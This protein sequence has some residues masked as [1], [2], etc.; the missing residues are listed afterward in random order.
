MSTDPAGG[1]VG[2]KPDDT[3]TLEE[4][5]EELR[6]RGYL[7]SPLD[8]FLL[9][10]RLRRRLT[11]AGAAATVAARAG[12]L[13]GPLVGIPVAVTASTLASGHG[14]AGALLRLALVLSVA[15]GLLLAL[16]EGAAA[17][18]LRR[19]GGGRAARLAARAG[20]VVAGLGTVYLA[21]WWRARRGNL[22]GIGWLD[23]LS[24][25]LIA[26]LA[27]GLARLTGAAGSALVAAEAAARKQPAPQRPRRRRAAVGVVLAAGLAALLLFA[28]RRAEPA[29]PPTGVARSDPGGRLLVLG[30]DGVGRAELED[31]RRAGLVPSL[32][33]LLAQA[34][35]RPLR[36]PPGLDPPAVWTTYATG[37]W[38][39]GHGVDGVEWQ[40]LAGVP[41]PAGAGPL[42]SA[43][44]EAA[45][46]VLPAPGRV[47]RSRP[48]SSQVRRAPAVWEILGGQGLPVAVAHWWATSPVSRLPGCVIGERAYAR[49]ERGTV[50]V[51]DIHPAARAVAAGR[52]HARWLEAAASRL[53][54]G[55]LDDA[56]RRALLAD[57]FAVDGWLECLAVHEPVAGFVYLWSVDVARGAD[58][59]GRHG[60]LS[61]AERMRAALRFADGQ[62][63]RIAAARR[64]EDRLVLILDPGRTGGQD[65]LL[66]LLGPGRAAPG[67]GEEAAGALQ[68]APTLLWL[69]GLPVSARMPAPP[70]VGLLAADAA[71]SLPQ[72]PPVAYGP[73][74]PPAAEGVASDEAGAREYLKS[75]GY[76][77]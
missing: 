30:L 37:L 29:A 68:V 74:P 43:L 35:V 45:D 40:S 13:G 26:L 23:L 59:A 70:A 38:P 55:D 24:I 52:E 16:L 2:G 51:G 33:D 1:P 62:A 71:G 10:D 77:E 36:R 9:R 18:I 27:V 39:A 63:A 41:A 20:V 49:L 69:A 46:A 42:L 5:R 17:V 4:I 65:G 48:V 34:A 76:I 50:P 22:G 58:A 31:A 11:R 12:L 60:L 56:L 57:L 66:A 19:L 47:S 21:L 3:P 53:P 15:F 54:D 28:G 44:L 72:R 64:P 6:R 73:P 61:A 75:L 25:A 32:D 14:G 7:D 8:R 67:G